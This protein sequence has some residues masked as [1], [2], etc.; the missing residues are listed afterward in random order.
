M[1][2]RFDDPLR[3]NLQVENKNRLMGTHVKSVSLKP[4]EEI[5]RRVVRVRFPLNFA[6]LTAKVFHLLRDVLIGV[7]VRKR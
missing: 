5:E 3:R 6:W 2:Y 1:Y 7:I 4:L